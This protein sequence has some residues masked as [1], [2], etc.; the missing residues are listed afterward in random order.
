[1]AHFMIGLLTKSPAGEK[2]LQNALLLLK[3]RDPDDI[4]PFPKA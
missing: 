3:N 4:F 1:M 2:S